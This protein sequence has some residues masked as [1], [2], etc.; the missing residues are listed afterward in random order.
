MNSNVNSPSID[1]QRSG[2]FDACTGHREFSRREHTAVKP[3]T[4][5]PRSPLRSNENGSGTPRDTMR[6]GEPPGHPSRRFRLRPTP[7]QLLQRPSPRQHGSQGRNR[8]HAN[9]CRRIRRRSPANPRNP[10]NDVPGR[11]FARCRFH[12]VSPP[13]Q[14]ALGRRADPSLP[15]TTIATIRRVLRAVCA[16]RSGNHP[17]IATCLAWIPPTA[18]SIPDRSRPDAST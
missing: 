15:M 6:R 1:R 3:G 2:R 14:V 10:A 12:P 16:C 13:G 9:D 5:T 11:H 4:P 8:P 17:L 18:G 7:A